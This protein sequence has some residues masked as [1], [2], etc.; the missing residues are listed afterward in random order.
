V[1]RVG[2]PGRH[3][4]DLGLDDVPFVPPATP[5]IVDRSTAANEAHAFKLGDSALDGAA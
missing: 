4:G 2:I 1:F 5:R 3:G